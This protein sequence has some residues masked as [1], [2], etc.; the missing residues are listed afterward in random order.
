M[1]GQV[2]SGQ[3]KSRQVISSRNSSSWD[4]SSRDRSSQESSKYLWTQNIFGHKMRPKIFVFSVICNS[5]PFIRN[6]GWK[7][8]VL[9]GLKSSVLF[10]YNSFSSYFLLHAV[11]FLLDSVILW[12]FLEVAYVIN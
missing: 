10:C 8:L 2:N 3:V 1:L 5:L 11:L 12:N 6:L 4:S 7:F 9:A